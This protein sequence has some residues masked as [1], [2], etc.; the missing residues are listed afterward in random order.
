MPQI[1]PMNWSLLMLFFF[2]VLA[3]VMTFIS[4][5][6]KNFYSQKSTKL[7]FKKWNW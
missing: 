1:S 3:S 4:F 2:W 6:N 5:E 7:F